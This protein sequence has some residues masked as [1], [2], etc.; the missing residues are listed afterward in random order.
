MTRIEQKADVNA[1]EMFMNDL[2]TKTAESMNREINTLRTD[3]EEISQKLQ[4]SERLL[5]ESQ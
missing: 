1:A 3:C 2:S 4:D 5:Q